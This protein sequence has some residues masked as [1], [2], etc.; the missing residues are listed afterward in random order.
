MQT[1]EQVAKIIIETAE[2][3]HKEVKRVI[4][5]SEKNRRR[6]HVYYNAYE[7][8][9]VKNG[10]PVLVWMD[11]RQPERDVGYMGEWVCDF[12]ISTM[13]YSDVKF[14]GLTSK[15]YDEALNEAFDIY[16]S[17]R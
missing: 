14:L 1:L 5:N 2:I 7:Q 6:F 17:R 9:E 3:S 11:V 15:D 10:F 13:N 16:C 12:D 8:V 4:S